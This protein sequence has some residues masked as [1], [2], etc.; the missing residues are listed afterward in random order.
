RP[1]VFLMVVRSF[2]QIGISGVYLIALAALGLHLL[3]GIQSSFQTWGL[4]NER[5]LPVIERTGFVASVVLFIWYAAI[6]VSI[7]MK[8][9]K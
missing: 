4:N 6:P 1:D 8:I 7:L 9:F 2:E 5:T 3:H